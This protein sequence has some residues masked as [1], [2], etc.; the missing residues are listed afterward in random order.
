[1]KRLEL[2]GV[3]NVEFFVS[4][5]NFVL[6]NSLP[7]ATTFTNATTLSGVYAQNPMH[8]MMTTPRIDSQANS[9]QR[10]VSTPA[11]PPLQGWI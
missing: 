10:G 11:R 5:L 9:V 2:F 7:K 6:G 1:M 4:I 8:N 3:S